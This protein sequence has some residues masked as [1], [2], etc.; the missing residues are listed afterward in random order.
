MVYSWEL[1]KSSGWQIETGK[2]ATCTH[3]LICWYLFILK[4]KNRMNIGLTYFWKGF[5]WIGVDRVCMLISQLLLLYI[6]EAFTHTH[7]A[8]VLDSLAMWEYFWE[9]NENLWFSLELWQVMKYFLLLL[10]CVIVWCP[11]WTNLLVDNVWSIC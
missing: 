8:Y 3:T 5:R 11:L 1:W 10:D 6:W 2:R 4:A 9:I 7:F